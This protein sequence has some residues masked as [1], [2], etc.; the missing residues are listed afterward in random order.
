MQQASEQHVNAIMMFLIVKGVP[1][2]EIHRLLTVVIKV[3][4]VSYHPG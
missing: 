3:N 1:S 2:L 4:S